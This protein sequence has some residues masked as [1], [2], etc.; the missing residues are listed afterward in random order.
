MASKNFPT[1]ASLQL[2]LLLALIAGIEAAG[3][4]ICVD[5]VSVMT[6]RLSQEDRGEGSRRLGPAL[7]QP[8]IPHK[9]ESPNSAVRKGE[10]RGTGWRGQ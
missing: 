1:V 4:G 5:S 7:P 3:E 10:K 9:G 8:A 6:N 2:P